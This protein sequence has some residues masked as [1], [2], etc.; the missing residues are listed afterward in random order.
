MQTY[1]NVAQI[2]LSIAL[3]LAI[4]LQVRG[5]GLGGIFGQADTVFRTKRGVERTL[6]QL[7]IVL[8]V[9]FVIISILSLTL[10]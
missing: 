4:L 6:F 8:V 9:L 7:T 10:S 2:V 3:I 1:L 5:G